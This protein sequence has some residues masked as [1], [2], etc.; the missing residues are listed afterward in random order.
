MAVFIVLTKVSRVEQITKT[1]QMQFIK[2]TNW[3]EANQLAI[4]KIKDSNSGITGYESS[5]LITLLCSHH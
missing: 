2:N 4:N 5:A 3:Q 1:I